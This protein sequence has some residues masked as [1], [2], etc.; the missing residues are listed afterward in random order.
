MHKSI[1]NTPN[2][3]SPSEPLLTFSDILLSKNKNRGK[4]TIKTKAE[5]GDD[6]KSREKSPS[7]TKKGQIYTK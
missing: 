6:E 7:G 2:Y 1:D 4:L 5:Q 3:L